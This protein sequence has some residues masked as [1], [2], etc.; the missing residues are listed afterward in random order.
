[1]ILFLSHELGR[2]LV[3]VPDLLFPITL[4]QHPQRAC[5]QFQ[6]RPD[7]T[8]QPDDYKSIL[9]Q[10]QTTQNIP[11]TD[12]WAVVNYVFIGKKWTSC[13]H[14][15]NTEIIL[16]LVKNYQLS[17]FNGS[18]YFKS[19][20]ISL[21]VNISSNLSL[22]SGQITT[23]SICIFVPVSLFQNRGSLPMLS[24]KCIDLAFPLTRDSQKLPYE[25]PTSLALQV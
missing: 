1:M 6:G 12:H 17:N 5:N 7:E 14:M 23:A 8:T 9:S 18:R 22:C 3:S 16:P 10:M 2:S 24:P 15:D 11:L 13:Y 25:Y 20:I 4:V 21:Q 19:S